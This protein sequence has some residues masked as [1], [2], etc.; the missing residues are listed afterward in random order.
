MNKF[1]QSVFVSG[2]INRRSTLFHQLFKY[3]KTKRLLGDV[4]PLC[5][6]ETDEIP[7]ANIGLRCVTRC[8]KENQ[9]LAVYSVGT[10]YTRM[11]MQDKGYFIS[12]DDP[13]NIFSNIQADNLNNIITWQVDT[14]DH[15]Y[16]IMRTRKGDMVSHMIDL[17]KD[18]EVDDHFR[19]Y[20]N[21]M[22]YL[23][24]V[25]H[26]SG[27]YA[28]DGA[29]DGKI[30]TIKEYNERNNKINNATYV[31]IVYYDCIEKNIRFTGSVCVASKVINNGDFVHIGYGPAFWDIKK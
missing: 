29:Y 12:K 16:I 1:S 31:P 15:V 30:K 28:N 22:S 8:I 9:P 5:K 11:D 20:M 13:T 2:V 26:F 25:G 18:T 24:D 7:G 3:L 17:D 27:A 19:S 6:L 21:N 4:N 23:Y 10:M 14:F